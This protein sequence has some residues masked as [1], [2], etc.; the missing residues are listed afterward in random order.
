[1]L[2]E[3][4]IFIRKNRLFSDE[5]IKGLVL[6]IEKVISKKEINITKEDKFSIDGSNF[7]LEARL[8]M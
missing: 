1:M 5:L 6:N 7:S 4:T 3:K 2:S 8:T